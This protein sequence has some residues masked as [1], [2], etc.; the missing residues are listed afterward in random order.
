MTARRRAAEI[1]AEWV[2]SC[3]TRPRGAGF[4]YP[5]AAISLAPDVRGTGR[6]HMRTAS[7][8][9]LALALAIPALETSAWAMEPVHS[10]AS[11]ESGQ[12]SSTEPRL[13]RRRSRKPKASRTQKSEPV[14]AKQAE[15]TAPASDAAVE[16]ATRTGPTRI[17]FD[18]RLLQG[19]TNKAN[20]IYLFQRRESALRSL[21]KKRAHFHTEIDESLE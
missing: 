15:E 3:L 11:F 10:R 16:A 5:A 9:G 17:E 18:E 14:R 20:A 19:Q 21:V 1:I 2:G 8:V 13:A 7:V 4:R 6:T 12:G